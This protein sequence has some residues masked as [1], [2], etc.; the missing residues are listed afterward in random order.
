[1]EKSIS[2]GDFSKIELRIG[3]ITEARKFLKAKKPAYQLL[4][5]LG[6]DI[7]LKKSSAQITAHYT[8]DELVGKQVL[9]VCNFPPK[10]IADFISEVL[11]TGLSDMNEHIVL[12]SP[13]FLIKN[14]AKLH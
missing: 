4:I 14:G 5:D 6:D 13:D 10:Q 7:G 2:W 11:V 3:T 1:M 12:L 9:C 8:I